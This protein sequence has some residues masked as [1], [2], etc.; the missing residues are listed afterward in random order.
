MPDLDQT[1]AKLI[2][3]SIVKISNVLGVW[4]GNIIGRNFVEWRI[5]NLTRTV[6]MFNSA[7]EE[8]GLTS[9]E[10]KVYAK[11]FGYEW[12]IEA[13]KEDNA[14][15]QEMWANLLLNANSPNSI[16][17][18]LIFIDILR[19]ISP[20][21]KEILLKIKGKHFHIRE[22][23]HDDAYL[24]IKDTEL[25]SKFSEEQISQSIAN[26]EALNLVRKSAIGADDC[27]IESLLQSKFL[28][29]VTIK[30]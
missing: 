15:I 30:T 2:E 17:P 13:S 10:R 19:K 23:K 6:D 25:K 11:K 12:I 14:T 27:F 29:A 20:I 5:Q 18:P 4:A 9:S 28:K 1:T 24:L 8:Q 7:C 3:Q 26:L 21:D 22:D 16:E